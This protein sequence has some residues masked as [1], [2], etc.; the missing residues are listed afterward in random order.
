[1]IELFIL[2][3]RAL[4]AT[5]RSRGDLVVEDL[6]LRHQLA[7]L[8]RPGRRRSPVRVRDKLVRIP[9]S[10]G[11]RSWAACTMCTSGPPERRPDILPPFRSR[12]AAGSYGW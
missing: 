8:A 9:A 6:L 5:L 3:L 2:L 1:M 12:P 4:R 7:V 10:V 11:V